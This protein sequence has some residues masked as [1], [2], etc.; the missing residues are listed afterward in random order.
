MPSKLFNLFDDQL[1][2]PADHVAGPV[3]SLA[4]ISQKTEEQN[5]A[6][7]KLARLQQVDLKVDYSDFS[8][9]VFFN[10]AL[11]YFNISAEKIINEY[12]YDAT[13]D[14]LESFV[15]DLDGYQRYL[16]SVWPKNT[17]HL[18]FNPS[19]S[20]SYV[21]VID[22]GQVFG[23]TTAG[24]TNQVGLLSPGTGSV[25]VE[26][27]GSLSASLSASAAIV[28]QKSS[29]TVGGDYGYSVYLSGAFVN[30]L[31]SSGS[32][33]S[34]VQAPL[35]NGQ[36]TY[37]AF[38]YDR[39]NTLAPVLTSYTGS[40]TSFPVSVSFVS[41]SILGPINIANGKFL[42]GSG[43]VT[44]FTG[45]SALS[46]ALDEVRVWSK[47]LYLADIS[48]TYNVQAYAQSGLQ[49]L[50]HFNESGSIS[51]DDGNNP[52][53]FDSSGHKLT[54]R[55]MNYWGGIRGSGSLVPFGSPDFLLQAY[56]NGPEIQT[57][58]STQ[59]ASGSAYDR[60]NDNL[61]TR[62]V[63]ENF[64]NL[65][66]IAGTTVLQ[67][68]LYILARQFDQIKVNID[69]FVK[70]LRVNTGQFDQTPDALLSEVARFFGWEFTGNFLSA[71]AFQYLLG[72]NVL[73]NQ[74]ANRELDVKLYQIK[75]EFWRRTLT[76]LMYLYKTKGTRESVESFMRIYGINKSFVR[77][78]E[79]GY[80]PNVG[81]QTNRI[82]ADKSVAALTFNS[83]SQ[84]AKVRSSNFI[85]TPYSIETRINFPTTASVGNAAVVSTGSI[86]KIN[87]V[88]GTIYSLQWSRNNGD[89]GNP[90]GTLTFSGSEGVVNLTNANIFDN[91]WY[92]VV[93]HRDPLSGT[94]NIDVKRLNIDTIDLSLSASSAVNVSTAQVTASFVL[95]S[96][97]SLPSQ[98]WVQEVRVWNK[99][100]TPIEIQD[101]TLNFQ[102]YGTE[103]VAVSSSLALHWR[104]NENVTASNSSVQVAVTDFAGTGVTGSA[105]GFVTGTNPY[106]K[107]L[108][109]YNYIA[110]PDLSWNEDKIRV[111][112]TSE[113]KPADV[114]Y[115]NQTMALEFNMIDALNEDI[116]QVLATLSGFDNAIGL[117]A[118]RYRQNYQDIESLRRQYFSK[119]QG[120]LN[121][122]V[123]SDMLE[124]FDRNFLTMVQRL[125]PARAI[126]L[127]DE[128]VVE[129]HMLERPKHQW[130]YRRQV[131][132]LI[133][134]GRITVFL[135]S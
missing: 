23:D 58:I 71:D 6:I 25:S 26:F 131:K 53:L 116:S 75:N 119:L 34:T 9:F 8:N 106:Q 73:A 55:I 77:L 3:Q 134:E 104:L 76:N 63:P 112:N 92:N 82:H 86:W 15:S 31:V 49:G 93:C 21:T 48:G 5:F 35:V 80:R 111:Y 7:N 27:W 81:I 43:T 109:D 52:L 50:W 121:F 96:T 39:T 132:T 115:E 36:L 46:G 135:R 103:V 61:I 2:K 38:V 133:P 100:L 69:Q 37:Y 129:S 1:K 90:T 59:Q 105:I 66:S 11:D 118:N 101:H 89:V 83:G 79:Y 127:G 130:N 12:P 64:L 30:F 74:D 51:P 120:R 17:G 40:A 60:S 87:G 113:L 88:S 57:L 99:N 67:D 18:R 41:S 10:S 117:P 114:Y 13:R 44:G 72:R 47:P 78:K 70:V 19:I 122:R 45:T 62:L 4:T 56:F 97:G 65:E 28:V 126:F 108:F 14:A 33:S 102:S 32:T 98:M 128:F 84:L 95:G 94:M 110:S 85:F 123:F 107:F 20:S 42:I 125:L 91:R 68:L 124:F 16:L 29:G 54:G 24:T 22:S